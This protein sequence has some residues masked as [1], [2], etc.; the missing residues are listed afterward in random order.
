MSL[1]RY[2]C[3]S[4]SIPVVYVECGQP[5]EAERERYHARLGL[6]RCISSSR[7]LRC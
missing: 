3:E 2:I 6:A 1:V 4:E 7:P 5:F